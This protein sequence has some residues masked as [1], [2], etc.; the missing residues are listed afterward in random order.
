[1]DASTPP[2]AAAP[3]PLWPVN[4]QPRRPA[5]PLNALGF[6][7]PDASR[8]RLN[9]VLDV[10]EELLSGLPGALCS[11]AVQALAS[12]RAGRKPRNRARNDSG[13]GDRSPRPLLTLEAV[14]VGHR[15][16]S[17]QN[18]SAQPGVNPPVSRPTFAYSR[19]KG[20]GQIERGHVQ[21][22]PVPP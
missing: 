5:P 22:P 2:K 17:A 12:G 1:M 11:N 13:P 21:V 19:S 4:P 7:L 6:S 20:E 9:S 15:R 10:L 3:P 8:E 14:P 16:P 18:L